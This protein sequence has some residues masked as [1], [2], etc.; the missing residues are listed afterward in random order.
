MLLRAAVATAEVTNG[1]RDERSTVSSVLIGIA[2]GVLAMF[3]SLYVYGWMN[4]AALDR[5]LPARLRGVHAW[6]APGDIWQT[7]DGARYVWYGAL[8]HVYHGSGSYALPLS[9]ILSVPAALLIDHFRLVEGLVWVP[10]P[11]AWLIAGPF[12]LVFGIFFLDSL[13]RIA[14]QLGVRSRLWR[15]Q[16]IGCFVVLAPAFEWGH[17]E[18]VIAL[19]FVVYAACFIL[20]RNFFV[21]GL[22][23]SLAVCSKQ[24]AVMAI[25]LMV[26][27][28]P[29]GQ[30]RK[31]I[32]AACALPGLFV[33]LLLGSDWVDT[34]RGL[35][36][37][38]NLGRKANG[39]YSFYVSW[40]GSQT[41]RLSRA[42]GVLLCVPAGWLM[43]SARRPAAVLGALSAVFII[44][45]FA[46]AVNYSY[47]WSPGLLFAGLV[48][49]AVHREIRVRDWVFPVL[50]EVWTFPHGNSAT[51]TLWWAI[52]LGLLVLAGSHLV[53]MLKVSE[54]AGR[55]GGL[56]VEA[57]NA[58]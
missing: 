18:D 16:V 29:R 39:H 49:A 51:T 23:I 27:L 1:E 52:E 37:P 21:S 15:L 35:F 10:R 31:C 54:V 26:A 4:Q 12:G 20:R 25:P 44:R 28:A 6:W 22:L 43:R 36:L 40:L 55:E 14:W 17:F 57:S 19:T 56:S 46:E 8:G 2:F 58:S 24:W 41:S 45:P 48:G 33:G 5:I 53:R 11:S 47:Y 30:R 50:A 34:Y 13:R 42:V 7:I 3:Y 9:F 38:I 32:L